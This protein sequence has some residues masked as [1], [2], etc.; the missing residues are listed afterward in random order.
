VPTRGRLEAAK[1]SNGLAVGVR[2]LLR[3][4]ERVRRSGSIKFGQRSPHT[5]N[6]SLYTVGHLLV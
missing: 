1:D 3:G 6:V 5:V 2:G 4:G